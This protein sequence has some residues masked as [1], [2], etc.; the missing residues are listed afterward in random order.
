MIGERI[1]L[2]LAFLLISLLANMLVANIF[3]RPKRMAVLDMQKIVDEYIK[4]K[5]NGDYDEKEAEKFILLMHNLVEQIAKTNK[6][7]IIPKQAIFGGE[8]MDI[9]E[10]FREALKNVK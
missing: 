10:Q 9:T 5:A 1:K 8:D 4:S 7:V 3:Y 2:F 6:L